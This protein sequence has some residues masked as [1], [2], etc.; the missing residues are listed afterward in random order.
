MTDIN[1][2][3]YMYMGVTPKTVFFCFFESIIDPLMRTVYG[4]GC[5]DAIRY[6]GC[7]F[8]LRSKV[9]TSRLTL[10]NGNRQLKVENRKSK[11]QKN[12]YAL[13]LWLM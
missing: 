11:K 10:P 8:N 13:L 3:W 4:S 5:Y 1:V 9:D 6:T 7:Y 2:D 12:G